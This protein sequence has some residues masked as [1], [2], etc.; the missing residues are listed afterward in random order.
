MNTERIELLGCPIDNLSL[1]EC[2]SKIEEFIVSRKPH[3]Y[4]AINADKI[5]KLHKDPSF[6]KILLESNLNIVDGQ[7]LM[8]ISRLKG[9][10]VKQR[11]GGI[12]IIDGFLPVAQAKGYKVYFLGATEDVVQKVI[13]KY[14]KEYPKLR[15]AGYRNGY[16]TEE[17]EPLIIREIKNTRVD[18]L[19]LAMGSP[20]KEVFLS[21]YLKELSIPFVMG[22]GG[23]FDVIAGKTVRAPKWMQSAGMEWL[24]RVFQ[25][26]RR[27]FKRYLVSNTNFLAIAFKDIFR[28]K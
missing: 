21:R 23:A 19:F 7:P 16:W 14:S 9:K 13:E 24:W 11:Y 2:I 8:W 3:Q 25:E 27:M 22:V 4:I 17:Q 5:V 10:P 1:P 12:D 26:P 28:K 6:K 18:V 20:K 15:I